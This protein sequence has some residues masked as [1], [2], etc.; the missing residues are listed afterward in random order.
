MGGVGLARLKPKRLPE[1][2]WD[3]LDLQPALRYFLIFE[4]SYLATLF[5]DSVSQNYTVSPEV[6]HAVLLFLG[7]LRIPCAQQLPLQN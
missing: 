4:L 6:V 7:V 1:F 5:L 2:A 3:L